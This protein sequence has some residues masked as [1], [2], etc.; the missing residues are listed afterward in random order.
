MSFYQMLPR[1]SVVWHDVNNYDPYPFP[2]VSDLAQ[3]GF[4]KRPCLRVALLSFKDKVT[5]SQVTKIPNDWISNVGIGH[6]NK[7]LVT[8][9]RSD[10]CANDI[11]PKWGGKALS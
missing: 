2:A 6:H 10:I 8:F 5:K 3:F 4:E 11:R 9:V 1:P 7:G